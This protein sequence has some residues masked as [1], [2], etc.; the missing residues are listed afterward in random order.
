MGSSG[1]FDPPGFQRQDP[2]QNRL[3]LFQG[4]RLQTSGQHSGQQKLL[5]TCRRKEAA[6]PHRHACL[7]HWFLSGSH[8]RSQPE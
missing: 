3:A 5:L 4:L 1:V 7:T 8:P 2:Q 6:K